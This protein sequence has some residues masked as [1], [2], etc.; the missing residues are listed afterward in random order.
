MK[1]LYEICYGVEPTEEELA[2]L[3][4][5]FQRLK[6]NGYSEQDAQK[7][8]LNN[9]LSLDKF[10]YTDSIINTT[11]DSIY[12]HYNL[13]IH[14]KPNSVDPV[15]LTVIK[16]PYYL[17]MKQRYTMNDLLDY[18]YN[19]LSVPIHFRDEKRDKGA[20]NHLISC[21][22]FDEINTVDFLLFVIDY[23]VAYEYK[24]SNPLDLKNWAQQTYEYLEMNIICHNPLVKYREEIIK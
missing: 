10:E 23:I 6:D 17:E 18:Y 4:I 15:T 20:F 22:K 13:Q 1:K 12:F 9:K 21:Y 14:S 5:K 2:L 8:L 7:I 3:E 11:N 24:V 16:Q 19:K